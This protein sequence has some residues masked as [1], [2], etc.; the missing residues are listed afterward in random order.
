MTSPGTTTTPGVLDA[1]LVGA[2]R[3]T[4]RTEEVLAA[5]EALPRRL[6]VVLSAGY[7]Q[8]RAADELADELQLTAAELGQ[9]CSDA[10]RAL[11]PAM[12]RPVVRGTARPHAF[13]LH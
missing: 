4:A 8:G 5:V 7:L 3:R 13:A 6:R 11:R 12:G 9:L 1:V 2:L 10:L